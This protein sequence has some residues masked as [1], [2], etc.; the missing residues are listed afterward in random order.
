MQI[1]AEPLMNIDDEHIGC[2][3]TGA[4]VGGQGCACGDERARATNDYIT[5]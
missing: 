1:N 5:G 2:L 3:E 4:E